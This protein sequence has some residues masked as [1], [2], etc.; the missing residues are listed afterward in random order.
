M[1]DMMRKKLPGLC[2]LSFSTFVVCVPAAFTQILS[3]DLMIDLNAFPSE[4]YAWTFPVFVAGECSS[5]ALCASVIDRYGRKNPFLVGSVAFLVGTV[6]C[7]VSSGM[8]M[9]LASRAVQG[10]GTGIVIVAC[11]AQIFYD[12]EDRKLRYMANGIMSL[13]FGLGMLVGVF[14]GKAVVDGLG[15]PLT[16]WSM[17]VLQAIVLYP[18]LRV[19]SSGEPSGRKA[20]LPGAITLAVWSGAFVLFLEKLYLD[21]DIL[22]AEGLMGASFLLMLFL[23]FVAAE[24]MNPDSVLQRKVYDRKLVIACMIFIVLLGAVDMAAVSAILK[25][26]FF[27]YQ[28]SVLDAAPYFVVLVLGAAVTA[29]TISKTIDRTGHLPW[30]LLSAVLSP[31]ALLSMYLVRADDPSFML[32]V[33]LFLLGLANGCLVS[34]LNGTIQNRTT[35]DNNGAFMGFA[36]LIRTA[37]L[38]LG[39]NLYQYVI[40]MRMTEGISQAVDHWNSIFSIQLPT[41]GTLANLLI[42][43][44][45]DLLMMLP[46]LTDEIARVY[47]EGVAQGLMYGAVLFVAV[48]VPVTIALVGRRKTL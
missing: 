41:D 29:I 38:W 32:G 24:V 20:D 25:I 26:A 3:L 27:T 17:A 40:D 16:F 45:R 30:L 42:T 2:L 14:L 39:Y 35:G 11:I 15:W 44:L 6:G 13:G 23:A 33:H 22:S 5:M 12:V 28:M 4:G 31:I 18:C 1:D 37:V 46:G 10:F 48:S 34:M 19:L 8:D 21:W 36:I 43:P 9:F 47:A 7:A